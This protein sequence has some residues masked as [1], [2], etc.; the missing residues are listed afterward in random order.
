MSA[1]TKIDQ[2]Q[3]E[4]FLRAKI[5]A[6][7][8][9]WAAGP[10]SQYTVAAR[11]GVTRSSLSRVAAELELTKATSVKHAPNRYGVDQA[12]VDRWTAEDRAMRAETKRQARAAIE[13]RL[14]RLSADSS[15]LARRAEARLLAEVRAAGPA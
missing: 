13:V 6:A 15:P 12:E 8:R 3:T 9:E 7:A 2:A 5:E 11:R 10:D 14:R 1:L 4:A